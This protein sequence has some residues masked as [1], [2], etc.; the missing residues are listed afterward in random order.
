MGIVDS[1]VLVDVSNFVIVLMG[2]KPDLT[3]FEVSMLAYQPDG[4]MSPS[5]GKESLAG[6][7]FITTRPKPVPPSSNG[8]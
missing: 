2:A 4:L 7:L 5:F 3:V 8:I 1:Y 6:A